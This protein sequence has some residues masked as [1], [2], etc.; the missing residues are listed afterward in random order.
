MPREWVILRTLACRRS[1]QGSR[2]IEIGKVRS[3]CTNLRNRN[4]ECAFRHY[5]VSRMVAPVLIDFNWLLAVGEK[6]RDG[7]TWFIF[8]EMSILKMTS[9]NFHSASARIS[10]HSFVIFNRSLLQATHSR[11]APIRPGRPGFQVSMKHLITREVSVD[12][13][14]IALSCYPGDIA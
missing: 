4:R 12:E 13:S 9:L 3:S 14:G 7:R 10:R 8:F 6:T 5:I 2:G 1:D 11:G